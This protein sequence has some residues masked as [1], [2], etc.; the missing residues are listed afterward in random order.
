MKEN[1]EQVMN[2]SPDRL[3]IPFTALHSLLKTSL[4]YVLIWT[5]TA[6]KSPMNIRYPI[7]KIP[8]EII[9]HILSFSINAN[10]ANSPAAIH[11]IP[12]KVEF[13]G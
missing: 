5:M 1:T 4:L 12:H 3:S 6:P 9:V 13:Y 2:S 7:R 8:A 10:K 11:R